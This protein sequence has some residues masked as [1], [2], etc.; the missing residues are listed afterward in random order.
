M[1]RENPLTHHEKL[2]Y[3][4]LLKNIH[5]LNDKEKREFAF[6]QAKLDKPQQEFRQVYRDDL[7]EFEDLQELPQEE[8]NIGLPTYGKRSRSSRY[9]VPKQEV[10]KEK[11]KQEKVK[12]PKKKRGFSFKRLFG[13]V[14]TLLL[15]VLVGMIIMFL[16][17]MQT[18]DSDK[19]KDAKAAQVEVFNG[20][21]TRDGVNI[22]ILGT[23][24][25]IGQNS[26]ETRTDSIMV[27]NVSGKDKKLKLVSFMRDNL[28]YIDGY[29]QVINGQKQT[30]HKLNLAYEL[31]EQEGKQGAEMVRKVL[32]DNFDLDIKYYALVDFQAFATAIDTLF[33]DGVTIDAQFSTLNGVPVTEATVGDDLHATETES[34]TQTIKVGT[35]QMNGSTLLNYARFRDDDEGDYGRTRRQQQ[36]MTAVLQQIKDPTKLF[37][38]SEALGKVFA[39]TSTNL[40]YTFIL[41]NGLS[42]LEGG[43]NGIER[44]TVP[45]LGDWVDD[46]DVYGGQSLR[47][48]QEAY[49][50]KLAQMGF[51]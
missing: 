14:F 33:P 40:P 3:D 32:K 38:G 43:Q 31:G 2:R 24:G 35:Q 37:T 29:S 1:T 41:T 12:K 20:Q 23:D 8:S 17:G 49:Q 10:N 25:R 18:A 46:Y 39:M 16:K 7:E 30:D 34:P 44:L 26:A 9:K 47:I 4:Y 11:I 15:L 13:W 28:V 22:L 36:V 51:R 42:V 27:L 48:D 50:K 45:E 19:P 21:D 5:Y 6:L